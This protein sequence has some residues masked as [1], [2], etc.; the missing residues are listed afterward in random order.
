MAVTVTLSGWIKR[1]PLEAYRTQ[2]RGGKGRNAMTTKEEDTITDLFVASTHAPVLF[3]STAGK[4]YRLKVW[5]LPEGTPQSKGRAMANL[6][7]LE[8]GE[9]IAA[10]LP[11]PEDPAEWASLHL[12]FATAQGYVRRNAMDSFTNVP[13]NGKLAIRFED[14]DDDKLVGVALLTEHDD[15]LLAARSG[16]AIRFASTDVREFQSRT[17]SG[18]RGMTLAPGDEVISLSVLRG[19][20]ATTEE[21]EAYLKCA[22]WKNNDDAECDLTDE[23]VAEFAAAEQFILTV[24]ANGFGK[25][26]SAYE[27]RR[28][29]RGGQG[30]TNIDTNDR[31]GPVVA[32]MPIESGEHVMLVTDQGKLIRTQAA[33][34]RIMGRG[35]QGVTILRTAED[36]HVA[37]VA[38]IR[39]DE[40]EE[41]A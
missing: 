11:L 39:D 24:T 23:R 32:S 10:V 14:G 16:K 28:T 29:N 27:Y 36:E 7:P 25:R 13:S 20:N 17:S 40:E 26:S 8:K 21:R 35:T 5:R 9:T 33:D 41:E 15:V 38:R 2:K 34:I 18:V 30:I 19:F 31:N 22:P 37:S 4:V 6:L 1:V 3:F 12:M